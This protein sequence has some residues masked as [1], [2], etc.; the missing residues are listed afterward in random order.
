[1]GYQQCLRVVHYSS[2][3]FPDILIKGNAE[4]NSEFSIAENLFISDTN[5]FC[6]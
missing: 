3:M 4:K 1:M 5:I 6:F 2:I